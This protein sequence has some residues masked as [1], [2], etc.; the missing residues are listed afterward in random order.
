VQGGHQPAAQPG[1]HPQDDPAMTRRRTVTRNGNRSSRPKCEYS[2]ATATSTST[3][4][5]GPEAGSSDAGQQQLGQPEPAHQ[6]H[7]RGQVGE[8]AAQPPPARRPRPQ[9]PG[10]G[11]HRAGQ[12]RGDRRGTHHSIGST[13][14]SPTRATTVATHSA[15]GARASTSTRSGPGPERRG[16]GRTRGWPSRRS[17]PRPVR[18]VR[19]TPDSGADPA[20]PDQRR[21]EERARDAATTAAVSTRSPG[22]PAGAGRGPVRGDPDPEPPE[23]Q[24]ERPPHD[25]A[26]LPPRYSCATPRWWPGA[27]GVTTATSWFGSWFFGV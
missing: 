10:D 21:N 16:E 19:P 24:P 25:H 4:G 13:G 2:A 12:H 5:P 23:Q 18:R 15:S 1:D 20:Q 22:D 14:N 9:P 3:V 8:G 6:G 17:R 26:P 27:T 7:H 11:G